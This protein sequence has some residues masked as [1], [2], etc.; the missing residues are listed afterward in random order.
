MW[1]AA[2]R[3]FQRRSPWLLLLSVAVALRLWYL[4]DQL[5]ADDEWHALHKV[6]SATPAEILRSFGYADHTI[7]LTLFYQWLAAGPGLDEWTMR[8]PLLVAGLVS[9]VLMP[10]L[11][12]GLAR[13]DEKLVFATLLVVSPLLV[14]FSRTARPYA[15][16]VLLAFA[17]LLAF[18][19]W[20]LQRDRRWAAA[21]VV[22]CALAAW[23]HPLTLAA[24][25]AP[26]L[27]HGLQAVWLWIR[28]REALPLWR[29]VV[30]GIVTAIP[31]ILLLGPPLLSDYASLAGKAGVHQVTANTFWRS[32]E[33][34]AGSAF[35]P[36]VSAWLVLAGAGAIL[37]ARRDP[38]FAGYWLFVLVTAAGIVALT[39]GEWIHHPLV[40]ARYLL[41]LLPMLLFL[42]AVAVAH[43]LRSLPPA[44]RWVPV[45][46]LA[47]L[48][49]LAGPL[50]SQYHAPINQFTGHMSFQFDYDPERNV[51]NRQLR[52]EYVPAF[53]RE[54]GEEP[55]G[56]LTLVV[57]PWYI[58]WHWNDWRFFQA[59]HRQRILA[60]FVT[61]LCAE[62]AFGEYPPGQ[63]GVHLRHVVHLADLVPADPRADFLVFQ[64]WPPQPDPRAVPGLEECVE[65]MR[66]RLGTP[67]LEADGLVVFDLRG[68]EQTR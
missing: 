46:G 20:W 52:P 51:Y 41:P 60:G 16:S 59:V 44:W 22:L 24:T 4:P 7:P 11:L 56:S 67:L 38:G 6:I 1:L 2:M 9:I 10:W 8:L 29:L 45:A 62:S 32:L 27:Y 65:A 40:L 3:V 53:Y 47:L 21:Y 61:G 50:P 58:E 42:V 30:I 57:A 15:L 25:L 68:A 26:F 39:G 14:Y 33:L 63:S 19:H 66:S 17:A 49:Y 13:A 55:P 43:G 18:R 48:L 36:L 31:L 35:L 23:L 54:L 37:L 5:L 34:F 28:E 12:R 64:L